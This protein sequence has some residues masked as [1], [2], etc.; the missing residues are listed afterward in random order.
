MPRLPHS[1]DQLGHLAAARPIAA[2]IG[3]PII[4]SPGK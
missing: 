2:P 4:T 1:H 3:E